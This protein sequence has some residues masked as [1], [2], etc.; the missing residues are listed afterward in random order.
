MLFVSSAHLTKMDHSQQ[1]LDH[2][3]ESFQWKDTNQ[4]KVDLKFHSNFINITII[5]VKT[6][7]R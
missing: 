1:Y 5:T 6:V 2:L 4:H 3:M 7:S